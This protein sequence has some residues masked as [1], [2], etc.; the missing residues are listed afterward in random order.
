VID[1]SILDEYNSYSI[2]HIWKDYVDEFRRK[3]VDIP[4]VVIHGGYG[5][6]N[7]GDD[8]ILEVILERIKNDMPTARVVVLAHGPEEVK[9]IHRVEAYHFA[10]FGAFKSIVTA[11][12]YVIGGGGIINVVNMYSGFKTFKIFDM[13]G[14]F[15]FFAPYL[16]K[17]FGAKTVFYAIGATSFPDP[18]VKWLARFVLNR[19]DSVFVRDRLSIA[20]L[21]EIGVKRELI[22]VLDPA[23]SLEPASREEAVRIMQDMG[24][25]EKTLRSRPVIGINLRYV[26]DP[27]V[28]NENSL[29]ET[30]RLADYLI[31]EK[32]CDVL[33]LPISQHPSKH[34]EDDVDF[35]RQVRSRLCDTSH[36]FMLSQYP[37]PRTMMALLGEM[38]FLI[39]TRL[40][41]VILGWKMNVPLFTLSY[42]HKV[43]EFVKMIGREDMLVSLKE[44]T[45]EKIQALIDPHINLISAPSKTE[46]H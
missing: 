44:F 40:H 11:N 35:G 15:I 42:N 34:F 36:F 19:V 25:E 1:I 43:T 46:G 38:D 6:K 23:L 10:S 21:Q 24:L 26:L 29:N 37:Y 3:G 27:K 4:R 39:L 2:T 41:S 14:K 31:Y 5:K 12:V 22:Q 33:F 17:M 45:L 8:A 13:K 7:L 18:V 16:A 32:Q 28:D 20:N 9:K 30:A